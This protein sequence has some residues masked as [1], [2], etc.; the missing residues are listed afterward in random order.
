MEGGGNAC[1]S[2]HPTVALVLH[3]LQNL[4]FH[5]TKSNS[6]F[7]QTLHNVRNPDAQ[8]PGIPFRSKTK[9]LLKNIKQTSLVR[10]L[11][12]FG[13]RRLTVV[14]FPPGEKFPRFKRCLLTSFSI[15]FQRHRLGPG[16]RRQGLPL[17][18]R[19]AG[20]NERR[21]G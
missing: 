17:H 10:S 21:E 16:R 2:G 4:I 18:H 15:I 5:F 12:E 6:T 3:Y 8:N 9:P 11:D 1:C 19:L 13:Y 14:N 7:G 20:E